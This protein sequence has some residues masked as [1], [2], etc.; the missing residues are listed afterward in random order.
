M[1]LGIS[2]FVGAT[3]DWD[4]D[5]QLTLMSTADTDKLKNICLSL[6]VSSKGGKGDMMGRLKNL[7]SV[8]IL[9]QKYIQS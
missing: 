2:F 9:P 5:M 4:D 8:T 7:P 6:N 3:E 1:G